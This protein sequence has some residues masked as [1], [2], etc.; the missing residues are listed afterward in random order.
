MTCWFVLI[1]SVIKKIEINIVKYLKFFHMT[2]PSGSLI[3][4]FFNQDVFRSRT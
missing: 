2:L 3:V 1:D 4:L